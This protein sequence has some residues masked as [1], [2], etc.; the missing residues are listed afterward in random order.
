MLAEVVFLGK[1]CCVNGVY[2]QVYSGQV[3]NQK[4]YGIKQKAKGETRL[5]VNAQGMEMVCKET[6]GWGS[7][8]AGLLC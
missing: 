3:A 1:Q 7:T 6:R 4:T 2:L 8:P 5:R